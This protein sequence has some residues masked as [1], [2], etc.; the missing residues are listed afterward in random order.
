MFSFAGRDGFISYLFAFL[1]QIIGILFIVLLIKKYPNKKIS[2]ISKT[3]IGNVATKVLMILFFIYF[4]FQIIGVDFEINSFLLEV[5]YEKLYSRIFLIPIFLVIIFVAFKGPRVMARVTEIFLPFG[6]FVLFYTLI[7]GLNNAKITNL[8]PILGDGIK[9]V[10]NGIF[11]GL[12]QMGEFLV[13][14]FIME[15]IELNDSKKSGKILILTAVISA[16]FMT[17]F[18]MLFVSVFGNVSISLKE[19]IIRMTQFSTSLNLN[20]RIDGISAVMWLPLNVILLCL[21][22][23]CAGKALQN[24][25]NLKLSTSI[26]VVFVLFFIIKFLPFITNDEIMKINLNFVAYVSI[27]L[28]IIIPALL[29]I[30]SKI[31]K[32]KKNE[33]ILQTHFK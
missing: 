9:P 26:L 25:F 1:V 20:F 5:F 23:Y 11:Y 32:E 33:K 12:S 31:K 13:L 4:V 15:N 2:D 24:I 28:Q 14:F 18:Y 22:F 21:N 29:F 27:F 7:I 16:L 3:L 17:G 30:V 10:L 6:V 8:L 19:G